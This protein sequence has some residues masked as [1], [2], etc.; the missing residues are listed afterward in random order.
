[1]ADEIAAQGGLFIRKWVRRGR[2]SGPEPLRALN[3]VEIQPIT[4]V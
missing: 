3:M 2:V 4:A 1:M